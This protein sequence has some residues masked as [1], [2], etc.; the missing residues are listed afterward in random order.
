[1]RRGI[2][3]AFNLTMKKHKWEREGERVGDPAPIIKITINQRWRPGRMQWAIMVGQASDVRGDGEDG[4]GG[5]E[6]R[7]EAPSIVEAGTSLA[8]GDN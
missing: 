1:M 4:K 5:G 7:N 6:E 8:G 2:N 3:R